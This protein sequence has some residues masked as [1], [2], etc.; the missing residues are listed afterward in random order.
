MISDRDPFADKVLVATAHD[1][2]RL[3]LRFG[4]GNADDIAAAKRVIVAA[5][6]RSEGA[7]P[8]PP[9]VAHVVALAVS[10]RRSTCSS[11]STRP[12]ASGRWTSRIGC[13]RPRRE[14]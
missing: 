3:A 8:D 13:T 12:C 11:G 5:A 2:R 1:R 4:I 10:R 14:R 6:L 9:P 7:L